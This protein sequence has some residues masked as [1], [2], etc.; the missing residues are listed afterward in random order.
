MPRRARSEQEITEHM[1]VSQLLVS[2]NALF[3]IME[4]S[5]LDCAEVSLSKALQAHRAAPKVR[6]ADIEWLLTASGCCHTDHQCL[7]WTIIECDTCVVN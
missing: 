4:S 2:G 6:C 3:C 1:L 7:M 5:T